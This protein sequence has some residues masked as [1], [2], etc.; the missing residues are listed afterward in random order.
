MRFHH[1]GYLVKDIRVSVKA[2]ERLGFTLKTDI[3]ID[4]IREAYIA[5]VGKDELTVELIQPQSEKSLLYNLFKHYKNSPY[6]ICFSSDN[7]VK[8]VQELT[9]VG[10]SCI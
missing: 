2:F 3:E 8:D 1:I 5:F 10:V 7:I 6:H 9:T 4:E